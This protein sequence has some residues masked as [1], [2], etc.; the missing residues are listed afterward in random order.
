MV[1]VARCGIAPRLMADDLINATFWGALITRDA[2]E[3]AWDAE[4]AKVAMCSPVKC[5][6]LSA[7]QGERP[8]TRRMSRPVM[9]P[10]MRESPTAFCGDPMPPRTPRPMIKMSIRINLENTSASMASSHLRTQ[11]R[12]RS[13]TPPAKA[14]GA[15]IAVMIMSIFLT[16]R[17]NHTTAT[18][19]IAI[20]ERIKIAPGPATNPVNMAG[21]MILLP[22]VEIESPVARLTTPVQS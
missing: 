11:P 16:T 9:S 14:N 19:T 21:S 13:A 1:E 15:K 3:V 22:N 10:V 12:E 7:I 6:N 18:A 8:A 2:P 5:T 17:A 4:P 20:K